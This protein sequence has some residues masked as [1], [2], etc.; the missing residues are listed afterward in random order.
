VIVFLHGVPETAAIWRKVQALVDQP[1]TA[2]S[3]PGF[4]TPRPEGYAAT[5]EAYAAWVVEELAAIDEPVDLVGHDWG[6]G[7]TYLVAE[8]H[9]DALRSWAADVA[10]LLHP[11]YVWHPL[12]QL[13]QTPGD[14]E[15]FFEGQL[16]LGP[17]A[18]AERMTSMY[19]LDEPD[20]L[21]LSRGV[22]ATMG[23]CI[24]DLYRSATPNPFTRWGPWHPTAAAGCV[25]DINADPLTDSALAAEVATTLGARLEV[26]DGANHFWPYTHPEAVV[27]ALQRFW[28]TLG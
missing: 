2:L 14:G 19:G 25:L 21:E 27:A 12:A 15:S 17:D 10:N 23:T 26:V 13:W 7:L 9:G 5:A 1:S 6:A 24:L 28:S 18:W 3:L 4:G 16:S 20:A 22:D 11:D 8:E